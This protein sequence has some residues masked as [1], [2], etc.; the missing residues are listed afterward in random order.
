[1]GRPSLAPPR[2]TSAPSGESLIKKEQFKTVAW[3]LMKVKMLDIH[4]STNH[5]KLFDI[6]AAMV[7]GNTATRS[8]A[9]KNEREVMST[10]EV[11]LTLLAR[12][13]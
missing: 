12:K 13:A 2:R 3:S 11:G 1:M 7:V 10:L 8:E 6:E 5:R 9:Q 4:Q